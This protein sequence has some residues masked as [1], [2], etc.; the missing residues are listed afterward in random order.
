MK[1]THTNLLL[2]YLIKE[3]PQNLEVYDFL[4]EIYDRRFYHYGNHFK[5]HFETRKT[6]KQRIWEKLYLVMAGTFVF[7][8]S[9]VKKNKKKKYPTVLTTTYFNAHD[10]LNNKSPVNISRPPWAY[11]SHKTNIFSW[12]LFKKSNRLKKKFAEANFVDLVSD[13]FVAEVKAYQQEFRAFIIQNNIIGLFVAHD[14]G[15]FEKLA[16]STFREVGR[17]TFVFVH[18]L[19]FWLNEFDFNRTDYLVVWGEASRLDFIQHGVPEKK[20]IVSGHPQYRKKD[21]SEL[22]FSFERVLVLGNALNGISPSDEYALTDRSNCIYHVKLVQ[23]CLKRIGVKSALLR[24]HPSE[25]AAWYQ[26]NTDPTFYTIDA[27]SIDETLDKST[28]VIGPTS[29]VLLDA[30]NHQVNYVV[31]N[32]EDRFGKNVNGFRT[33]SFFNGSNPKIPVAKTIKELEEI[34]LNKRSI[35]ISILDDIMAREFSLDEVHQILESNNKLAI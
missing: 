20:I 31:F 21:I 17:P 14:I 9:R 32:P 19:Q 2:N 34:L 29:T 22:R 10:F 16:I 13:E 35:D 1:E 5:Y 12:S 8:F 28:L 3:N 4:K 11:N 26:Q 7:F 15:F 27:D 18:G 30:L 6:L 23:D 24:P 25:N 33:P